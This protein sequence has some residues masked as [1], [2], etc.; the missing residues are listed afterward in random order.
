LE[1]QSGLNSDR[2]NNQRLIGQLGDRGSQSQRAT[3]HLIQAAKSLNQ[4]QGSNYFGWEI[5]MRRPCAPRRFQTLLLSLFA[6]LALG[7]A[8]A[9][10]FA[11]IH[12]TVAQRTK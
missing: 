2:E 10:I 7:L 4:N 12:Y 9:G 6:A 5:K 11:M 3:G 1:P 8:G